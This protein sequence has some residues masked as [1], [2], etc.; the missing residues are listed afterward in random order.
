MSNGPLFSHLNGKY[1]TRNQ[2]LSVLRSA[3]KFSGYDTSNFNTHSFRIG[4]ATFL[5]SQGKSEAFVKMRGRWQSMRIKDI[6]D[7]NSMLVFFRVKTFMV[8]G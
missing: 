6:L 7:V 2:F 1:I 4:G 5:A 3:L 8:I